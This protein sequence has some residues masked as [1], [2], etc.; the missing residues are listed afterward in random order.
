MLQHETLSVIW[1]AILAIAW[2]VYLSLESFVVGSAM[3]QS[4]LAP[5]DS[6]KRTI[7]FSSGL[8]WDGIEV[9][10]I[11]AIGGTFA[12]FPMVYAKTLEGLYVPIFL[13]LFALIIRG[14]TIEL[15]YKDENP[16]WQDWM[17]GGWKI[18]ST[19]IPF[20]FGVYFAN[21][22]LG[23]PL[24]KE[25]YEGSF[26]GLIGMR[27]IIMGLVFVFIARTT[28]AYWIIL[29][30]KPG[31]HSN[32]AHKKAFRSSIVV[33]LGT[34]LVLMTL[35][36]GTGTFNSSQLYG[37]YPILWLVPGFTVLVPLLTVW[38]AKKRRIWPALITGALTQAMIL[39]TGFSAIFPFMVPSSLDPQYGITL[40]DAASSQ[41]TLHV[42]FIMALIFVPL[43]LGYQI[44][45]FWYFSK[46]RRK[47]AITKEA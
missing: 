24:G 27:P 41:Y 7:L 33:A 1:F 21:L 45:K 2:I 23:L 6:V 20:V 12:A 35:N 15:A 17:T 10:L 28:G 43:V 11:T 42:M 36:T 34:I 16:T 31:D 22:F 30:T 14:V 26:L 4:S 13:L 46:D 18:S 37:Q 47:P 9:W 19:L 3:L 32:D 8:H 39:I 40:Y 25:G 38:F 5:N 29:N 44:W